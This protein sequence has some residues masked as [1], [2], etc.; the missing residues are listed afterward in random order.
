MHYSVSI[1]STL[2]PCTPLQWK[3]SLDVKRAQAACMLTNLQDT[4]KALWRNPFILSHMQKENRCIQWQRYPRFMEKKKKVSALE[5]IKS[6]SSRLYFCYYLLRKLS[7]VLLGHI[8]AETF[9][10][11]S[12]T[13]PLCLKLGL[14]RN[15][16]GNNCRQASAEEDYYHSHF[17]WHTEK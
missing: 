5:M 6:T 12:A 17:C 1:L 15:V 16:W 10:G 11:V 9:Q 8:S 14:I 3:T 4:T 13:V 7:S 2:E